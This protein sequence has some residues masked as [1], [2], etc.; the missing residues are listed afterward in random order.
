MGKKKASP[1][2]NCTASMSNEAKRVALNNGSAM[3]MSIPVKRGKL[4]P[5]AIPN[6]NNALYNGSRAPGVMHPNGQFM[7]QY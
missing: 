5:G 6:Y 3:M 4:P 7:Y 1:C 2:T